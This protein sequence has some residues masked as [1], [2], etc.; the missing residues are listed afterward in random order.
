VIAT[1][2]SQDFYKSVIEYRNHMQM[3][4]EKLA[5]IPVEK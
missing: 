4:S 1:L 5:M 3:S 2:E